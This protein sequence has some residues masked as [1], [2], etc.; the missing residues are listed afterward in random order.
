MAGMGHMLQVCTAG[1][2]HMAYTA[3]TGDMP[4]SLW[5]WT[6]WHMQQ[7]WATSHNAVGTTISII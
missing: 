3:C 1:M 4:Y 6:I 7:T 2:G 5:P